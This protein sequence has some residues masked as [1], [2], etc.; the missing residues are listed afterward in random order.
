LNVP[1]RNGSVIV[2]SINGYGARGA[3]NRRE[4]NFALRDTFGTIVVICNKG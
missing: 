4:S 1:R 3:G 2:V